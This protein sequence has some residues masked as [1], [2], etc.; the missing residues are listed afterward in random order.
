V[1]SG[2]SLVRLSSTEELLWRA[3]MR[4]VLWLPR[5][6][7]VDL[8]Q[9]GISVNEYTTLVSLSEAPERELRMTDLAR[10]TGLSASRM[11][12]W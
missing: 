10:A 2:L 9:A 4:V 7:D 3:L 1:S 8:L 6:L 12:G 11:S 5:R